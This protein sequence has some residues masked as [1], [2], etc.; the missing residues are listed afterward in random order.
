MLIY[1]ASR[2]TKAREATTVGARRAFKNLCQLILAKYLRR[3]PSAPRSGSLVETMS[4]SSS[5]L[6]LSIS[7]RRSISQRTAA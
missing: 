6:A 2:E 5:G 1:T 4:Y 7:R 3:H